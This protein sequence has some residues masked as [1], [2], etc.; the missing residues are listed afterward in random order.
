VPDAERGLE[1]G[2]RGALASIAG[3]ERPI[4]YASCDGEHV[5]WRKPQRKVRYRMKLNAV[6]G[7]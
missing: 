4:S 7:S 2:R 3:R 5:A 1:G 6:P